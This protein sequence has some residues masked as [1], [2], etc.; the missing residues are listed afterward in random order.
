MSA[1][2]HD[3]AFMARALQLAR[4]GL[5]TTD[6]NPRVGCVI[7]S[8]GE[9][10]GEGWHAFTG[11]PHAEVAALG[12]AGAAAGGAT[13]YVTLEP[14]CHHGRMPPCTDALLEA[15]IARVVIASRD[16]NPVVAGAGEAQLA[17]A[18]VAVTGGVLDGESQA[19]NVGYL[20]RRRT[21]RPYVRSKIAV[22]MDGR[23]AL[24]NGTSQWITGE[25]ARADVQRLRARSSAIMV[26]AGTV[27]DDD[28]SLN[29][30]N[31][32][33]GEVLQPLRII[34]DSGLRT[35]TDARTLGLPGDV[36]VFTVA[37]DA[38]KQ[39]LL[40]QAGARIEVVN[41]MPNGRVDLDAALVRLANLEVNEVLVEAGSRLN[42]ALLQAGVIDELVVYMAGSILGRDARGMF[43]IPELTDMS[44]RPEFGLA[45]VRRVGK[46]LRLTW[47]ISKADG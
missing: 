7:V 42:G 4:R 37:G 15:G 39:Q 38:S 9:I 41:A 16:P 3:H 23:T 13:A 10:V 25:A 12:D 36:I 29:V 11:G 22:S 1:P 43:D 40:E 24:A 14:C 28:P 21:G 19:L 5:N 27:V 18:G 44:A 30:R 31:K 34:I 35:P 17:A 26:G 8:D 45:D 20:K 46:D 47:K 33:L 32:E 6:P 2:G